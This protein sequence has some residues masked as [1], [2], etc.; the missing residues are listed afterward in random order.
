M[1][2]LKFEPISYFVNLT[3]W[4]KEPLEPRDVEDVGK[5]DLKDLSERQR[6]ILSVIQNNDRITELKMTEKIKASDKTIRREI[7][8]LQKKGILTREGGRKDGRWV[9]IKR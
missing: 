2:E 1:P 3:I 4:F 9:I 7:A 5:D 6:L 8:G